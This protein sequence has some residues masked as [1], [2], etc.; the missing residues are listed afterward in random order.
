MSLLDPLRNMYGV[1]SQAGAQASEL[2]GIADERG[3]MGVV[4]KIMGLAPED[5]KETVDEILGTATLDL[6]AAGDKASVE[7]VLG[8]RKYCYEY[9]D[10]LVILRDVLLK[11]HSEDPAE[12]RAA[13]IEMKTM[14]TASK[15]APGHARRERAL[16]GE[17]A[18]LRDTLGQIAELAAG[19]PIDGG[20]SKQA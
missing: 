9:L 19:G 14:T 7:T 4:K 10:E 5:M 16:E 8:F 3:I 6:V 11:F 12:K 15:G 2:L 18:A 1:M 17:I 20:N 13:L